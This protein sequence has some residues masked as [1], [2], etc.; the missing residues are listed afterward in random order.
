MSQTRPHRVKREVGL[1][2]ALPIV[3]SAGSAGFPDRCIAKT[4]LNQITAYFQLT[5]A[6]KSV[7]SATRRACFIHRFG[8]ADGKAS[9][10]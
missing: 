4:L 10:S 8:M 3:G 6:H 9:E 7:Q 2:N 5:K 1:L